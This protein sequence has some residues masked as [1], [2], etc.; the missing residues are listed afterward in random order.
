MVAARSRPVFEATLANMEAEAK[1]R[2]DE[3][4]QA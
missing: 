3:V 1:K 2:A 4:P